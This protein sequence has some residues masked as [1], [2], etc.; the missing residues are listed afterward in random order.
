MLRVSS[1]TYPHYKWDA[2]ETSFKATIFEV[3]DAYALRCVLD[4][5]TT[6]IVEDGLVG[7]VMFQDFKITKFEVTGDTVKIVGGYG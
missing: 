1:L 2:G 3:S 7:S 4:T 6:I 5:E